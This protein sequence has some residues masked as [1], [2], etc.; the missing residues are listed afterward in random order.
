M[1]IIPKVPSIYQIRHVSSGRVYVG[2]AVNTRQRWH[3]HRS[4]L[5]LGR[6]SS[7]HLQSA[8]NKYGE[9]AFVFEVIEPVLFV[10][11]LIA[12]EQYWIDR[13]K[14]A[15]ERHGYNM[16]PTAG[17]ALGMKHTEETRAKQS[18]RNR[19]RYKD[20]AARE[21]Q[22]EARRAWFANPA[23][24]EKQG[25]RVRRWNDDPVQRERKAERLRRRYD[26]PAERE[27]TAEQMRALWADPEYRAK[28][29][30]ERKSRRKKGK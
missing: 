30:A 7:R 12:R 26:D 14:A 25:E 29:I 9:A 19:K 17:S 3:S 13:L 1:S 18:E 20:P 6:H 27:K 22:S 5:R 16:S 28:M 21:K 4:D 11:D 8:W 2:S 10:E 15:D 23:E 24:R